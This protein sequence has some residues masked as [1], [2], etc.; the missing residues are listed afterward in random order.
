MR[1]IISNTYTKELLFIDHLLQYMNFLNVGIITGGIGYSINFL[2]IL[3]GPFY[4]QLPNS[5]S[6]QN[7]NQIKPKIWRGSIIAWLVRCHAQ[8]SSDVT[9]A[10]ED[11]D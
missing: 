3:S 7:L 6:N 11:A 9:L 8:N 10:F 2:K 1:I 5:R 4:R